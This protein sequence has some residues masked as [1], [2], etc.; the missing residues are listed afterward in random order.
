MKSILKPKVTCGAIIE[1][2][3]KILLIKRNTEP[4]RNYWCLPGGHIE[5]GEKAEKTIR[6]EVKEETGLDFKPKFFQYQNE[7]IPEINWHSL[8]LSFIGKTKGKIKLDESEVKECKW[9][10]KE[11]IKNL[12]MAFRNKEILNIYFK[13]RNLT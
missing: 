10:S 5:W 9:F 6:R 8:A 11:E 3:G 7:I 2:K 13:I 12:K 1:R 4:Y